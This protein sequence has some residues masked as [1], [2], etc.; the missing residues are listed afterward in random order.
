MLQAFDQLFSVLLLNMYRT[1]NKWTPE[2]WG[3]SVIC[4]KIDKFGRNSV[5][6][7]KTLIFSEGFLKDITLMKQ[8][9]DDR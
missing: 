4:K 5:E 9:Q 3:K 6:K 7:K 2:I 1:E 8:E